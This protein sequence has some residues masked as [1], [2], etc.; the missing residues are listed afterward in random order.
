MNEQIKAEPANQTPS[1]TQASV[2]NANL[3]PALPEPTKTNTKVMAIVIAIVVLV[4]VA[5]IACIAL[6]YTHPVATATIRDIF[7]IALAVTSLAIGLLLLVLVFQMQSLIALLRN[8]IKPM[9]TNANQTVNTVR[10]TA[11]FVSDNLVKPTISVASFAA[12][13]KGV[14]QAIFGKINSASRR[15]SGTKSSHGP[16][17]K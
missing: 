11:V 6:L 17:T 14:Q 3:G 9:L 8:E 2:E 1:S 13:A 10:G 4:L 12:G 15:T 7:I 5:L 16:S